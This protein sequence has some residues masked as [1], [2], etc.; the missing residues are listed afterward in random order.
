M[1]RQPNKHYSPKERYPRVGADVTGLFFREKRIKKTGSYNNHLHYPLES[2]LMNKINTVYNIDSF[3]GLPL[4]SIVWLSC[5]L[6]AVC[7]T[8]EREK[9]ILLSSEPCSKSKVPSLDK[10]TNKLW[11]SLITD[12]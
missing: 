4:S 3:F 8:P 1:T 2:K 7:S 6:A 10:K 5:T 9:H 12:I 11:R